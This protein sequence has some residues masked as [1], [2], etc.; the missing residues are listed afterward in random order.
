MQSSKQLLGLGVLV[1][2]NMVVQFLFQWYI[3]I[4]FGAGVETDAFFGSM[5]LPQFILLVLSSSLTIVL[6]PMIARL[7]EN[8]FLVLSTN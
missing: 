3:T 1:T 2:T 7:N 5:A 8:E 4:A 6:I